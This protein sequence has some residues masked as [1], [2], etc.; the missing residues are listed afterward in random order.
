MESKTLGDF[1]ARLF[2]ILMFALPAIALKG[3]DLFRSA[4]LMCG[5]IGRGNGR[6]RRTS[7]AITILQNIKVNPGSLRHTG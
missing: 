1:F 7:A 3:Y 4:R 5:E 2:V 6:A